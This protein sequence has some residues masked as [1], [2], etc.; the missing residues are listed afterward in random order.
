MKY[1]CIACNEHGFNHFYQ[2][3]KALMYLLNLSNEQKDVFLHF[4]NDYEL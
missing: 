4:F 1:T 2:K 3:E